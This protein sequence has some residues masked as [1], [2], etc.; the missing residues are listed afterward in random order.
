MPTS[1]RKARA[2][3][4]GLMPACVGEGGDE[5][6]SS[7]WPA[8][9]SCSSREGRRSARCAEQVRGEL[10]L[11]AGP[12]DEHD[13]PA[14]RSPWP[15]RR[16]GRRSTRASARSSPPSRRPRSRCRRRARRSGRRRRS[17]PGSGRPG[18]RPTTS[19][20]SPACRRAGRRRRGGTLPCTPRRP[21]AT[22]CQAP[23]PSTSPDARAGWSAATPPATTSVSIGPRTDASA[24]VSSPR[25][26][27]PRTMPPV[28]G[29]ERDR[30][31]AGPQGAR[32]REDLGRPDGIERLAA[33]EDDD[34]HAAGCPPRDLRRSR[35]SAAM[36][37]H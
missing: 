18:G 1:S 37:L 20:W 33:L 8:I 14:G 19:A 21:A 36:P 16:R 3:W 31:G 23:D 26:L 13:E 6:S 11:A 9:Q 15:P 22:C 5:R 24:F 34:D 17:P 25:P 28:R 10:A 35:C 12:L 27:A 30:V 29:D 4:R 32:T 7:R 2:K